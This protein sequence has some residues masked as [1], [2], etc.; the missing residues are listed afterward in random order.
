[1]DEK[2]IER[3]RKCLALSLNNPSIEE[4]ES[5]ALTAQK[6]MAKHNVTL[7]DLESGAPEEEEK[8]EIVREEVGTGK[9]WKYRLGTIVAQNFRCKTFSY[10]KE[11]IAF[12]GYSTDAEAAKE[13]FCFLFQMGHKLAKT[14]ARKRIHATGTCVGVYNSYV[15]GFMD[16]VKSKLDAQCKA[17]L[18]VM[19]PAVSEG[20]AEFIKGAK[21]GSHHQLVN[22]LDYRA[23]EQG[24]Q[25]GKSAMG[26]REISAG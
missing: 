11:S 2:I 13:V 18:I 20:Y 4:A 25:S 12:Y 17:L 3:I 15:I 9:T 26:T 24:L 14:T 7:V 16:G 21:P 6:L 1:M 5:A 8:I 22:K 19:A 10:G 23:Y